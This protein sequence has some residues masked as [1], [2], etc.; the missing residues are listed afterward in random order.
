MNL[1]TGQ[2]RPHGNDDGGTAVEQSLERCLRWSQAGRHRKVL[3]EVERVLPVTRQQPLLRARVLVW[4]ATALLA[5]AAPERALAAA[6]KAWDLDASP[7]ACFM[8]SSAF[9]SLGDHDRSEELLRVGWQLFPDAVHLPV[10]LGMKLAD[11]DRVP[12]AL[13]VLEDLGDSPEMTGEL[14]IFLFGIRANLLA[15]MGR[16]AEAD[17]HLGE[18]LGL[19]PGSDLLRE[20]KDSLGRVR[21][22]ARAAHS[23]AS[24]W[25]KSLTA[26]SGVAAE[27]DEAVAQLESAGGFT[28]L[29]VLAARRLW[30]AFLDAEEVHPQSPDAWGAAL[31]CAVSILDGRSRSAAGVA[32]VLDARPST[33]RG[34]TR[35][36]RSFLDA[37]E[38]EFARRSFAAEANPRLLSEPAHFA[39]GSEMAEV[40]PFPGP[41][42]GGP[43]E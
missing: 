28:E 21:V 31:I 40:V 34:A 9:D 18:G 26:L 7:H 15:K 23:L 1:M 3:A 6:S 4:K 36:L 2:E 13:E 17:D 43:I 25:K 10:Q 24:S 30:R 37:L 12:E 41:T 11:Q 27:V 19:H 39:A 42:A 5:M 32:R 38:P 20:T 29:T 16:W 14:Q 35:R 33:V 8:M 22:R